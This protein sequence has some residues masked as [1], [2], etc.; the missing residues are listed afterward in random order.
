ML[1]SAETDKNWVDM[2]LGQEEA[3]ERL[4]QAKHDS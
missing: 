4:L 1:V 3:V 2:M